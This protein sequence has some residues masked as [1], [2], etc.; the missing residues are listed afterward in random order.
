MKFPKITKQRLKGVQGFRATAH[1]M[2]VLRAI[3]RRNPDGTLL[4][5]H[6][7]KAAVGHTAT[8][9]AMS[10][11]LAYLHEHGF[12]E[13]AGTRPTQ[14]RPTWLYQLTDAGRAIIRPSALPGEHR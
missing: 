9:Q 4:D 13:L 6:Q 12:V 10:Y 5:I 3:H 14:G 11:T 2:A 1:Q 8:K 7:L